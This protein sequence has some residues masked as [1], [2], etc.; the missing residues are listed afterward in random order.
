MSVLG[1][2]NKEKHPIYVSKKCWE[3]KH[4]NLISIEDKLK[5]HYVLI[6]DFNKFMY[7]H[8]LHRRKNIFVVI[9]HK[10]LVQKKYWHVILRTALKLMAN[11]RLRFLKKVNMLNS[12][13]MKEKHSLFMIYANF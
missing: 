13:I 7:N 2:E 8:T 1:Y 11:K 3:E 4:A 5:K 10:I 12:K 9:V 6:K